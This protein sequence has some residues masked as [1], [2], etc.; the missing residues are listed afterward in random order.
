MSIFGG[1]ITNTVYI[2][3]P[4]TVYIIYTAYTR[5]LDK[6]EK[7][8]FLELALYSSIYM[9]IRYGV[10]FKT[11]YP[12]LLFNI[13][14]V[15]S[16]IK[17]QKTSSFIIAFILI[18][19][20]YYKLHF[21][22]VILILEYVLYFFVYFLCDNTKNRNINII[23]GFIIIRT[24]SMIYQTIFYIMP[25]ASFL[26]TFYYILFS[27]LLFS[28]F[29]YVII[30]I[31]DKGENIVNY[32]STLNEL[33]REKEIR[34]SLFKISHEVKNPLAVCRGYL[35]ILEGQKKKEYHKYIPII[36]NEINRTLNLMDD[37]LD[38]TKVKITKEDTDLYLLL[39]EIREEI[40]PLLRN[41][42][43]ECNFNIPDDELYLDLD[44]NR[45][46]QVFI[47]VFKNSIEAKKGRMEIT[48]NVYQKGSK[49]T[50]KISDNGIGMNKE[51]MQRIG[52][53]FFTTKKNGTG[54]GVSLSKEIIGL[55]DGKMYYKSVEGK[56][57]DAYI[58][59]PI[60]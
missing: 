14:L 3:F 9:L 17:N 54:L 58:E 56:G 16:F 2:L 32:N 55:H 25:D 8:L 59:L 28:F 13:P 10:M 38:Y 39:E 30:I 22:L 1:V 26:Q 27:S 5:N 47:N 6:K 45:I 44:Y 11:I 35:D 51:T 46:K 40:K 48:L 18:L 57:T 29:S 7:G 23:N 33:N 21:S 19:F 60:N 52:E 43:I 37:F 34:E 36:S 53:N 49:V 20:N 50:I 15:I 42:D 41:N 24:I 4:L 31:I 12:A